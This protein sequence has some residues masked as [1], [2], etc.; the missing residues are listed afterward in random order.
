MSVGVFFCATLLRASI[1]RV[2]LFCKFSKCCSAVRLF[3]IIPCSDVSG[4]SQ[5]TSSWLGGKLV[6][7]FAKLL[8]TWVATASQL[9]QSIW[10]AVMSHR[11]CSTN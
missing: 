10:F 2:L 5:P 1:V 6:V 7:A 4:C 9:L 3:D 11:Y 8:C